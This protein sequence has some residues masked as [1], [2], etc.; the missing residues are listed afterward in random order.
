MSQGEVVNKE[1]TG[2]GTVYSLAP[3]FHSSPSALF[4][5]SENIACTMGAIK[6][7]RHLTPFNVLIKVYNSF[8]QPHFDYCN[9]VGKL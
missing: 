6:R 7:I 5:L 3:T 1:A 9:V 4:P 8:I 2:K